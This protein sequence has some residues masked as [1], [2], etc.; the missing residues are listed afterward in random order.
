MLFICDDQL[1]S[2]T[3]QV[4]KFILTY[5]MESP[6]FTGAGALPAKFPLFL[7]VPEEEI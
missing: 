7:H 1:T 4:A 6:K 5:R 2:N 3:P